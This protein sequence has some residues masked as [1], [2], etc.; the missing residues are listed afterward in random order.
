MEYDFAVEAGLPVLAFLHGSPG[1]IPAEKTEPR[2]AGRAALEKFRKRVEDVRHVKYWTSAKELPGL[3]FPGLATLMKLKPRVGWVHADA[4]PD[5]S[6]AQEIL[7]L[8]RQVEALQK[9]IVAAATP[10]RN[11]G[12]SPGN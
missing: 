9:Q 2:D 8:R 3:V 7:K 12:S 1:Q 6:A 10:P 11:R 4:V 5:E